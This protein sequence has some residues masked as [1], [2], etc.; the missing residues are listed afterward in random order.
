MVTGDRGIRALIISRGWMRESN[1]TLRGEKDGDGPS[2]MPY[3]NYT[4]DMI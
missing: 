4:T 2:S 3:V 1:M